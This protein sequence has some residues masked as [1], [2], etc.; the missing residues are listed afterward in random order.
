MKVLRNCQLNPVEV[1]NIYPF[2]VYEPDDICE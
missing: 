2:N 1:G